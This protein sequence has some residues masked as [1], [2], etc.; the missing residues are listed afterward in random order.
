MLN[1]K[2]V[3][4]RNGLGDYLNELKKYYSSY[5]IDDVILANPNQHI[6]LGISQI[7]KNIPFLQEFCQKNS[8]IALV[9]YIKP[10]IIIVYGY[11]PDYIFK[12]AKDNG[13]DIWQ[14]DS[15][16]SKAFGGHNYG[17]EI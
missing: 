5:Q 9:E 12:I 3:T 15:E 4:P 17:Y 1:Y 14:Y 10:R 13:S 16:I 8:V 6:I 7:H 2:S 11:A